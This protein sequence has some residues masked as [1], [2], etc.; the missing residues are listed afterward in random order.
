MNIEDL[1][2]KIPPDLRRSLGAVFSVRVLQIL[3]GIAGTYFLAHGLSQAGFGYY[4]YILTVAALLSVLAFK[5]LNESLTQAV[6][7]GFAGTSRRALALPLKGSFAASL[8]LLG[9]AGWYHYRGGP[10]EL[11]Q[12]FTLA[13]LCY[14]LLHGL[15]LW[16]SILQGQGRFPQLMK[17]EA[18]NTVLATALMIGAIVLMPG[19][20]LVPLLCVLGIPALQNLY[21]T[22]KVFST[23][24]ADSPV[25]PG[26]IDYGVKSS[27]YQAVNVVSRY[28]DKVL[29]FIF[30]S[31]EKLAIFYAAER[32]TDLLRNA[33]Q[34]AAVVL[35]PRFARREV[36]SHDLDR[37]FRIF[38]LVFGAGIVIFSFTLL[39]VIIR[40]IFGAAYDEAVPY[41][42][43]L[44]CSVAIG[45]TAVLRSRYIRSKLDT[46]NFRDVTLWTSYARI[47]A[48]LVLVPFF[49]IW[50]AVGAAYVYRI[51]TSVMV[52]RAIRR[53]YLPPSAPRS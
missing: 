46:V 42:Q 41:A 52:D 25:E 20:I 37:L 30:L 12:G 38:S 21:R 24:S 19:N 9:L 31:P 53:D 49:G 33:V 39:P 43:A 36:F 1:V 7:R 14:P 2:R 23:V 5:G 35:T 45:N 18:V 50:G 15:T 17:L 44:A 8:I 28:I 48:V 3:A 27:F 10:A 32:L 40:F 13:A 34:D 26:N 22:F 47:V 4:Q 11:V 29:I 6:A 51:S 16:K